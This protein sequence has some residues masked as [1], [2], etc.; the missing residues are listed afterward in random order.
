[1]EP[2]KPLVVVTNFTASMLLGVIALNLSQAYWPILLVGIIYFG[3]LSL[4]QVSDAPFGVWGRQ[5]FAT[6]TIIYMSH[7]SC[8]LCIQKYTLPGPVSLLTR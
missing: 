2:A 8:V 5:V 1:M 4:R 7:T 3:S 6:V